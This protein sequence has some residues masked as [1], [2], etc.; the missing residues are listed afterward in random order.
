ME[1]SGYNIVVEREWTTYTQ[2]KNMVLRLFQHGFVAADLKRFFI[3]K[4][5]LISNVHISVGFSIRE[6]GTESYRDLRF[7]SV[8][9]EIYRRT[10]FITEVNPFLKWQKISPDF[11][12][13][14]LLQQSDSRENIE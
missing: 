10:D 1:R 11:T 7:K 5:Y 9:R 4:I 13:Y 2:Y 6:R 12:K 14:M 3:N 8:N